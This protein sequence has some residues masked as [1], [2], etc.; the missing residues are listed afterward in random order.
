MVS[1]ICRV[2]SAGM[3][4]MFQVGGERDDGNEKN[5]AACVLQSTYTLFST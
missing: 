1:L 4:R 2:V 5:G 3:H